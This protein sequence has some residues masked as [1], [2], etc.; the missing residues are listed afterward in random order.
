[1][2]KAHCS[3]DSIAPKAQIFMHTL[4]PVHC[5]SIT[6]TFP[7]F[8]VNAGQ[9]KLFTHIMQFVHLSGF[10]RTGIIFLPLLILLSY[11]AHGCREI[12]TRGPFVLMASSIALVVASRSF[13]STIQK[14]SSSMPAPLTMSSNGILVPT[15]PVIFHSR[16]R[17]S[18]EPSHR[19]YLVI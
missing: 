14:W 12:K 2:K 7:S 13:E 5:L 16:S 1:M 19:S 9:P 18:L 15:S 8:K 6:A 4:Q 3:V 17:M 10:I 11:K